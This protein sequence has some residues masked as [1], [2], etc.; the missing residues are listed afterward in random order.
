MEARA[1]EELCTT[2]LVFTPRTGK[3]KTVF[4][5]FARLF[6]DYSNARTKLRTLEAKAAASALPVAQER[7]R[8]K[9]LPALL[10]ALAEV[11]RE[12]ARLMEAYYGSLRE[13]RELYFAQAKPGTLPVVRVIVP[14]PHALSRKPYTKVAR[15][16]RGGDVP[17]D[18]ELFVKGGQRHHAGSLQ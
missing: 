17:D 6:I 10:A 12:E 5:R 15:R 4:E 16:L 11:M 9:E 18:V 3:F 1:D 14:E 13:M 8:A 2:R 7:K